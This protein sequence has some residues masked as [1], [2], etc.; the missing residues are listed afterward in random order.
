L[1]WQRAEKVNRRK[2]R[3]FANAAAE[4]RIVRMARTIDNQRAA[5]P[6]FDSIRLVRMVN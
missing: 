1:R 6:Q 3:I 4:I 2:G 5:Q